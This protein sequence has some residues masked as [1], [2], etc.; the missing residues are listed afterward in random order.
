MR[1]SS[2]D[3]RCVLARGG[4][5]IPLSSDHKPNNVVVTL[6]S[7]CQTTERDRI[8]NAGGSV[9]AGRVNGDLAVRYEGVC[10][11]GF[12]GVGRFPFQVQQ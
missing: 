10:D 1:F 9:M 8:N 11:I 7:H 3:S 5:A 12:Q 6:L 2:G 4:Q